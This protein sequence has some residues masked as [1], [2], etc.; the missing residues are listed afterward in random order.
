MTP[1]MEFE[2]AAWGK[3]RGEGGNRKGILGDSLTHLRGESSIR[4]KFILSTF[5]SHLSTLIL[6]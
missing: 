1:K 4:H 6:Q 3:P 5:T 2:I